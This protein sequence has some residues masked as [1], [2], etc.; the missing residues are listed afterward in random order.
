MILGGTCKVRS[1]PR[2]VFFFFFCIN[3]WE[4]EALRKLDP[5]HCD[6]HS[7]QSQ[8]GL[9]RPVLRWGW[10][11]DSLCHPLKL[12]L[13][14]SSAQTLKD[15]VERTCMERRTHPRPPS[16][17]QRQLGDLGVRCLGEQG[18]AQALSFPTP[19]YHRWKAGRVQDESAGHRD[20]QACMPSCDCWANATGLSWFSFALYKY[21]KG[22]PCFP[23]EI[24]SC[25]HT[26][27]VLTL[28]IKQLTCMRERI[29][30]RSCI[31]SKM[32]RFRQ[33]MMF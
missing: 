33:K 26:H 11:A 28:T 12:L 2:L 27:S 7:Q 1:F 8:Q 14:S 21:P 24:P 20:F 5:N 19:N 10:S 29:W 4:S 3:C 30:K 32:M 13:P 23:V 31:R 9:L 16:F 18:P 15:W 17:G 25:T 22:L 6:I